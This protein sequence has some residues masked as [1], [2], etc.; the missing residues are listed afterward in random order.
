MSE[1]KNN[2]NNSIP[3]TNETEPQTI[4]E[5]AKRFPNYVR[6]SSDFKCQKEIGR[7]GF[8]VVWLGDDLKTNQKV[9]VKE[10]LS[11]RL[12]RR[13]T[14]HFIREIYTMAITKSPFVVP[15][16]GFTVE[17][18]FTIITKFEENGQLSK[19]I[20]YKTSST[21][22]KL[23]GTQLTTVALCIASALV[24]FDNLHIIH[25]D[26]KSSNIL[27]DT[28][29]IPKIC[30]F[31]TARIYS[32]DATLTTKIGTI[33]FM[34]PEVIRS[35]NYN[36][37]VDVYDFG[38]ILY[39]MS[40]GRIPYSD[41]KR[42]EL[43][44]TLPNHPIPLDFRLS[45]REMKMFIKSLTDFDPE[46][47]PTIQ[48][49]FQ[50]FASG[51]I[52]FPGTKKGRIQ[53]V[54]KTIQKKSSKKKQLPPL[55]VD[56]NEIYQRLE[57][58]KDAA[59]EDEQE[60]KNNIFDSLSGHFSEPSNKDDLNKF[61]LTLLEDPTK[62]DYIKHLEDAKTEVK[63]SQF[64]ELSTSLTKALQAK[65]EDKIIIAIYELIIYLIKLDLDILIALM[66]ASF[67]HTMILTSDP[68]KKLSIEI[69]GY[70][71]NNRPKLIKVSLT[72]SIV[73]LIQYDPESMIIMLCHYISELPPQED[74]F[75][76]IGVFIDQSN[77]IL[78]TNAEINYICCLYQ[79]LSTNQLFKEQSMEAISPIIMKAC[80]S[81]NEELAITSLQALA[82]L[83]PDKKI[84]VDFEMILQVAGNPRIQKYLISVLL[85]IEEFPASRRI[86]YVLFNYATVSQRGFL[87]LMNFCA[88]SPENAKLVVELD[89]W[90]TAKLPTVH[91]TFRLFMLLF[92]EIEFRP[93]ICKSSSYSAMLKMFSDDSDLFLYTC[94]PSILRRSNLDLDLL[95][96]LQQNGFWSSFFN[97]ANNSNNKKV[98]NAAL[99]M[100]DSV[101]AVGF[102]PEFV[103]FITKM[104]DILKN[105]QDL[106]QQVITVIVRISYLKDAH[107][108][109][110]IFVQY[111]QSL[112]SY[113]NYKQYAT[114]FLENLGK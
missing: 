6:N 24:D 109:L 47:R 75:P 61:D 34:C 52:A 1:P 10:F 23:T 82:N 50:A 73:T 54:L 49:V 2:D 60:E 76:V 111:F 79:L 102:I 42:E 8:G 77:S 58:Q 5:L 7:G 74:S 15:L 59:L 99:V 12:T 72:K 28:E 87:S 62:P 31:G 66:K 84:N 68:M 51:K 41:M 46:K 14:T 90:M 27:M 106:T 13:Q 45:N 64:P 57:E 78:G 92:K 18:P 39:E 3:N 25:R 105:H 94:L 80:Q 37:K 40:E 30:D 88:S 11:Y 107:E 69:F 81:N 100:A 101:A 44:E 65:P 9:A 104:K 36:N 56:I 43:F 108:P 32:P 48:E 21:A 112:T 35:P 85:R 17:H 16:V 33:N 19:F 89:K 97:K 95:N 20:K 53:K 103:P 26:L 70:L 63:R 83:L 55:L 4:Y 98:I 91:N 93:I 114:S 96:K 86:A 110:E 29:L 67:F 22:P 71:F 113:P 38:M